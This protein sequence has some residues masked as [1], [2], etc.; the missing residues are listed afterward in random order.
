MIEL[1]Y[2]S[3][4]KRIF[5]EEELNKILM[6]ARRNNLAAGIT[7]MLLY[8]G[9]GTFMQ[10]IEGEK[11]K[12]YQLFNRIKADS[13]HGDV[14][15]LCEAAINE[16]SFP[17]WNM[18]YKRLSKANTNTIQGFSTLLESGS[19]A[20]VTGKNGSFAVAMLNHFKQSIR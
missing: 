18:G 1:V 16:R 6:S 14:H 12:I 7:G 3:Q 10:A 19:N 17:D 9:K 2:M 8:D 5:T 11:D 20:E 15:L 4:A 13:R